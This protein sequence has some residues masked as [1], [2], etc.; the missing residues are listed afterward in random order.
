MLHYTF[1]IEGRNKDDV[2]EAIAMVEALE[3]QLTQ[4]EEELIPENAEVKKLVNFLNYKRKLHYTAYQNNK[5]RNKD[6]PDRSKLAPKVDERRIL[7]LRA[8]KLMGK[9]GEGETLCHH[10]TIT[11]EQET[12]TPEE[13]AEDVTQSL[14]DG[15]QFTVDELKEVNLGTIEEPYP[16]FISASLSSEKEY[17]EMTTFRTPKGIYCY[18]MMPFGL[19]NAGVIYQRAMQK[20]FD[21]KLHKYVECYVNDLMVKSKRRQGHLK[22]PKVVFD[23]LQKYQL[24]MNPLK[25]AFGMT[26]QKFIGCTVRY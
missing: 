13:D 18:K 7:D 20:V 5:V 6:R 9:A 14:E 21:D 15:D 4:R 16:T 25:Y 1:M 2:E 11:L 26:S 10:I 17:E 19:K 23:C 8:Y 22:D 12:E 24:R 3:V